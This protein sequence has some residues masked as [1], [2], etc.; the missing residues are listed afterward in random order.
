MGPHRYSWI[1]GPTTFLN[2]CPQKFTIKK[3]KSKNQV[4]SKLHEVHTLSSSSGM[5]S[6]AVIRLKSSWSIFNQ[7]EISLENP[8]A[9]QDYLER[10]AREGDILTLVMARKTWKKSL[11][12]MVSGKIH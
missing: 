2:D 6:L 3:N 1:Y 12:T 10:S 11:S 8:S 4:N 7:S 9:N 5:Q